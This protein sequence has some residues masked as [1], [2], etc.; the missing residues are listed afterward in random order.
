MIRGF[1]C[2]DTANRTP[3]LEFRVY[4]KMYEVSP[5]NAVM[6]RMKNR[7]IREKVNVFI[8]FIS[9]PCGGDCTLGSLTVE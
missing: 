4:H 5:R 9:L 3:E 6:G 2:Q 1:P 8:V 7:T